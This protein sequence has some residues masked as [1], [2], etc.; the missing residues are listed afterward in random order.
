M[1]N[2]LPTKDIDNLFAI[3]FFAFLMKR[4][5]KCKNFLF[6]TICEYK[7]FGQLLNSKVARTINA[8]QNRKRFKSCIILVC[9]KYC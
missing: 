9:L 6:E 4:E 8:L 5:N 3:L 7:C 2:V 1:G